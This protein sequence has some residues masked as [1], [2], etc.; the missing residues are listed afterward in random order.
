MFGAEG[1]DDR[2]QRAHPAQ[3]FH[4]F[5]LDATI[6]RALRHRGKTGAHRF[7]PGEGSD[8][9][10]HNI[11]DDLF[12]RTAGLFQIGDI[13]IALLRIGLDDGLVD[14]GEARAAQE[15]VDGAL[16][17]GGA[18][19]LLFFLDVGRTGGETADIERQ[20]ARRPVLARTLIGETRINKRIGDHLLQIASRLALHAGRDFF[21]A[22]FEQEIGHR[23]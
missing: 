21:G 19:A 4:A 10:R 6:A 7:R 12:G 18:R 23:V 14:G 15:A 1:A 3:A 8:D 20:A 11:G 22:E 2:L 5:A 16:R 13:E 9:A 17:R